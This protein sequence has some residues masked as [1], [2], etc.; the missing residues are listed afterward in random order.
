VFCL[1]EKYINW[2]P[3][4]K[5]RV[6]GKKYLYLTAICHGYEE[7]A[8]NWFLHICKV[9]TSNS[10]LVVCFDCL[11]YN[12]LKKANIP[13]LFFDLYEA[14]SH[15]SIKPL[16]KI[17]GINHH[18]GKFL[19][20]EYFTRQH[21]L[22]LIYLDVDMIVLKD[23]YSYIKKNLVKSK[24]TYI[25]TNKTLLSI[26]TKKID[27]GGVIVYY[28]RQIVD[29]L[30]DII[31]KSSNNLEAKL[32]NLTLLKLHTNFTIHELNPF[33]FPST[34]MLHVTTLKIK[35]AAYIIHYNTHQEINELN[36]EELNCC[37]DEKILKMKEDNNW[38][39]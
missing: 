27:Y 16:N 26:K 29:A 31:D 13:C 3:H 21:N 10:A 5:E 11:S 9:D 14:I 36:N 4:L 18:T 37:I 35:K 25:F 6:F 22:E 23:V 7:L 24:E 8:Q 33:L 1:T 12:T 39:I 30:I 15:E 34:G 32:T 17:F 38:L 20:W 28:N 2:E 19:I